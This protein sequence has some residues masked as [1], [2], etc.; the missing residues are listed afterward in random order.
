VIRRSL[1][2]C[3]TV[4]LGAALA[5]CESGGNSAKPEHPTATEAPKVEDQVKKAVETEH[6]KAP[7]VPKAPEH[8]EHPK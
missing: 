6:P 3:C 1:T 4:V 2:L 7:E 8:P 5:G